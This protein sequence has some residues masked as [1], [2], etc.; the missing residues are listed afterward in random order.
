MAPH[1]QM[2]KLRPRG[3]CSAVLG[4][5]R[6]PILQTGKLRPGGACSAVGHT[7][8]KK[9]SWAGSWDLGLLS[10]L[11]GSRQ[12][13]RGRSLWKGQGGRLAD[14]GRWRQQAGLL[15]SAPIPASHTRHHGGAGSWRHQL[16]PP[17]PLPTH[18]LAHRTGWA[19]GPRL[20]SP[21]LSQLGLAPTLP[22]SWG[23]RGTV[24]WTQWPEAPHLRVSLSH[25]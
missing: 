5:I 15:P 23:S 18:L 7:A 16:L 17:P 1:L 22:F 19:S 14:G 2:G 11:A 9:L 10:L 12:G 8:R 4:H 21:L 3:A 13:A 20:D 25:G 24:R 6:H